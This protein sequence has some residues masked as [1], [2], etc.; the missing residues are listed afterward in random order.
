[1]AG[2]GLYLLIECLIWRVDPLV[3]VQ[4]DSASWFTGFASFLQGTSKCVSSLGQASDE[5]GAE[6]GDNNNSVKALEEVRGRCEK[7]R[8]RARG[9]INTAQ[10]TP[11]S[12]GYVFPQLLHLQLQEEEKLCGEL[13]GQI[14]AA[15]QD[16]VSFYVGGL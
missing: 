2:V 7:C 12:G 15:L 14:V 8:I 11:T 4:Q 10:N 6:G 16:L 13:M 5:K 3:I 9:F 1:M